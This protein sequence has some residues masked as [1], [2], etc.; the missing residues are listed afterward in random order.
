ME[1]SAGWR[2]GPAWAPNVIAAAAQFRPNRCPVCDS[3]EAVTMRWPF[4]KWREKSGCTESSA[5]DMAET[6]SVSNPK[7]H[8]RRASPTRSLGRQSAQAH[9]AMGLDAEIGKPPLGNSSGI[10]FS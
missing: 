9:L 8:A 7:A 5:G 2:T 1:C 4:L 10:A 6:S 3:L